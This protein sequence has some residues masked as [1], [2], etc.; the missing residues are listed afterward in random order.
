MRLANAAPARAATRRGV[1]HR[2][3]HAAIAVVFAADD[4]YHIRCAS[5]G[6]RS[7]DSSGVTTGQVSRTRAACQRSPRK[8]RQRDTV[9]PSRRL[10]RRCCR[11]APRDRPP[12][13]LGQSERALGPGD[14]PQRPPSRSKRIGRAPRMYVRSAPLSARWSSV[15]RSQLGVDNHCSPRASCSMAPPRAPVSGGAQMC[16]QRCNPVAAPRSAA[17]VCGRD[18][19]WRTRTDASAGDRW[20]TRVS[21]RMR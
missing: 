18:R 16:A 2:P 5:C 19:A 14:M 3:P 12:Q 20:W 17:L 8:E 11:A 9:T 21:G 13:R 10:R 4:P 1:R 6:G 15:G 7:P